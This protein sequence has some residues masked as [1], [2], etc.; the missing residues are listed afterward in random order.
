[1]ARL[2]ELHAQRHPLYTQLVNATGK[3]PGWNFHKY[4][5]AR[6]GRVVANFASA[7]E[8]MSRVVV[9]AVEAELKKP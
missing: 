7:M 3:A 9:S 4:L 8:P 2:R 5:I 1:M 6:D